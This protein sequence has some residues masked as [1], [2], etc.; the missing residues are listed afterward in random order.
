[1]ASP[2]EPS[3]LRRASIAAAVLSIAAI[4]AVGMVALVHDLAEPQIEA[5]RRA[6]LLA[7][8]TAV[9]GDVEYDNDPL[10][11]VIQVRDPELLGTDEPLTAHRVR[12]GGEP[13]AALLNAVAPDGYAGAIHLLIAIDVQGRVLGV[14]VLDHRETPG[15]GDPIEERR[16]DWIHGF[17]GRSLGQP[18]PDRWQVRKDGGDFDQF[19]GATVTPR[20]VVRAVRNT[21]TWF[22]RHRDELFAAP[23]AT[24]TPATP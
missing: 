17:D 5:S 14:R 20:A 21:L 11:D 10:Q 3:G 12:R 16:S 22:A 2:A 15:L 4:A 6:Q 8:L 13:V 19:T 24:G 18:P 1:M 23:A 9:L 7:Q